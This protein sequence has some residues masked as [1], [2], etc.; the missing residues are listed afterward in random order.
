M[1]VL[2]R[3][4]PENLLP[5]GLFDLIISDE[6]PLLVTVQDDPKPFSRYF[7]TRQIIKMTYCIPECRD[8]GHGHNV[9]LVAVA[10][11]LKVLVTQTRGHIH[12]NVFIARLQEIKSLRNSPWLNATR[13]VVAFW[14]RNQ[15]K[16]A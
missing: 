13:Q 11:H 7:L 12:E 10:N 6:G 2:I 16:T 1:R 4:F 15:V 8:F 9:Q 5:N 3:N 14:R